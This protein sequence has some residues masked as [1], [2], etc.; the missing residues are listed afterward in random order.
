MNFRCT[1]APS[2]RCASTPRSRDRLCRAPKTASFFVSTSGARLCHATVQPIFRDLLDRA[3]IGQHAAGSRP[4]IHDIR[5]SFAVATL[6][7][8]HRDGHDVQARIPALSTYLG[9][10]D[11]GATYW[12]LSAAPE[13]LALAAARLEADLGSRP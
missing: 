4:R 3:G 7:D 8:W 1:P 5:H 2:P 13:L 10:V 9:H 11:P 12:Y 6:L